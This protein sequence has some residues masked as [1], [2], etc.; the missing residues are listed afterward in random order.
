M[1]F[2]TRLCIF[3]T[4][5]CIGSLPAVCWEGACPCLT[6]ACHCTADLPQPLPS[7]NSITISPLQ[8]HLRP[9]KQG[10]TWQNQPLLTTQQHTTGWAGLAPLL[11]HP[12]PA[13]LGWDPPAP[14]LCLYP[15]SDTTM[16]NLPPW[17]WRRTCFFLVLPPSEEK[18]E[19]TCMATGHSFVMLCLHFSFSLHHGDRHSLEIWENKNPHTHT[20]LPQKNSLSPHTPHRLDDLRQA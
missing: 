1:Y 11:P 3:N 19:G 8:T 13:W 5:F 2:C 15:L 4:C 7:G 10:N 20:S 9:G 18:E 6:T 17:D 14:S 16:F 12:T